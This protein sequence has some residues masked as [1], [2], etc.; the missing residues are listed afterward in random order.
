MREA[1]VVLVQHIQEVVIYRLPENFL[2]TGEIMVER[3]FGQAGL[4]HNFLHGYFLIVL[5]HEELE[6]G[7]EDMSAGIF[8]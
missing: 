7:F 8:H 5:R 4:L 6:G 1:P 3:P 2:F